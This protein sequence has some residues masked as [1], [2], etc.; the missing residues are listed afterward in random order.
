[1]WRLP[2]P[3]GEQ[4]EMVAIPGGEHRIGSSP[5]EDGRYMYA[6]QR[7]RCVD[8]HSGQHLNVEAE[9]T[10]RLDS[11][12]MVRHLITHA[13]W[14]A[15]AALPPVAENLNPAPGFFRPEAVWERHGQ[16]GALPA[17]CVSWNDCQE[18]L[19]RLNLWL[20]QQWSGLAGSGQAPQLALPSEGQWE[21]AC[22]AG[23][24]T[25]FHFGEVLDASWA[26]F[27]GSYVYGL[28][29]IGPYRKRPLPI[30]ALGLANRWGL[31]EMHGQ[32]LEWCG[33]YWHPDPVG[34][35]WPADGGAWEDPDRGLEGSAQQAWRLLRGGSLFGVPHGCRAAQRNSD[36]P[37]FILANFG[38][39]PCCLLPPGS[40]PGA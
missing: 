38:V 32:L 14:Q 16:P 1:V 30:G 7:D 9:R 6:V 31:V 11:Y 10:V 18:W 26:N 29:R 28:S 36:I 2:L 40:L 21:V 17:D 23:A 12:V 25:P 13:Q 39:R 20:Q 4:L 5:E 34:D 15:V 19:R 22:R 24:S 33:D 3:G 37:E 35:G 27:N 8:P